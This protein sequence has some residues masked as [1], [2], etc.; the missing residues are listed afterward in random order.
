[1]E[2]DEFV[3]MI[4]YKETRNYVKLVVRNREM[5]RRIY[6]TDINPDG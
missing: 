2:R 3:E 4:T 1:M 5:Y 6:P